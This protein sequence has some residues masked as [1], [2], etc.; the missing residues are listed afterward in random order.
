MVL[1]ISITNPIVR[2]L[3]KVG[4]SLS[5]SHE[6]KEKRELKEQSH[7]QTADI[8]S[9]TNLHINHRLSP[10]ILRTTV[11]QNMIKTATKR[12]AICL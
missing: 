5:L 1:F 8:E 11:L 4:V 10:F 6:N 3:K 7:A 9:S 12:A 2:I